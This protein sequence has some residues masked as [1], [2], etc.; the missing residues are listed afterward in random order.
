VYLLTVGPA[1]A[2]QGLAEVSG[3]STAVAPCNSNY[4]ADGVQFRLIQF[5]LTQLQ[6]PDANHLRNFIAYQCFGVAEQTAFVADPFNQSL[7]S[8]GLLDKLR[9]NQML[10]DC[11]VPLAVLYWTATDGLV[12]VD[13]WSARRRLS[14]AAAGSL[15]L[16][17][18]RRVSEGEAMFLQFEDQ[19]QSILDTQNNPGLIAAESQFQILPPA[20]MLPISGTGSPSG[21]NLQ[22]FFGA[23]ASNDIATTNGNLLREIFHEALYHQPIELAKTGKIQLYLIWENLQAVQH[24]NTQQLALVFASAAMPYRGIARFGTA[25]WSLSRFAPRVI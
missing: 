20:G 18:D 1:S 23:H 9:A 12:Y 10:T 11:E 6:P 5:D 17:T 19:V 22:T 3:I 21:F 8:H 24:G 4:K 16:N 15:D 13:M 14:A 7:A 2:A 25:K